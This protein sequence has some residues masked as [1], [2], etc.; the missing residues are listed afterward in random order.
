MNL[1]LPTIT[2]EFVEPVAIREGRPQ[3]GSRPQKYDDL[4]KK[5]ENNWS[6]KAKEAIL[7]RDIL[8]N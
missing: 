3:R 6:S 1:R 2:S 7:I 8:R 4:R 5:G